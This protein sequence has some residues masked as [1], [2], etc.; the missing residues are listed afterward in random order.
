MGAAGPVQQ[1]E[2][3]GVESKGGGRAGTA[4]VNTDCANL[5]SLCNLFYSV[6]YNS[7]VVMYI[8]N[9][10]LQIHFKTLLR[11]LI[12]KCA[13]NFTSFILLNI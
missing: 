8:K 13:D 7:V 3:V 1:L 2:G 11:L 10:V 9:I 4:L 6:I 12:F 5:S